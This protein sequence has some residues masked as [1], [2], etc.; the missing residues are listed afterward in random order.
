[1]KTTRLSFIEPFAAEL[2]HS[3][4]I[5]LQDKR[6]TAI[7]VF[8]LALGIGTNVGIFGLLTRFI[9]KLPVR[10]PDELVAFR[11]GSGR[12]T[13]TELNQVLTSFFVFEELRAAN[14]TLTGVF[15]FSYAAR[16]DWEMTA[17]G[18]CPGNGN[19]IVNGRGEVARFQYVSGNYFTALGISAIRGRTI[20][21]SDDNLSAAPV[22]MVSYDYWLQRFHGDP[23]VVGLPAILD[24]VPLTI[25][26]VL[27]KGLRDPLQADQRVADILLPLAV[28][29]RALEGRS[30]ADI[31]RAAFN[32]GVPATGSLSVMG[33]RKPG[34]TLAQVEANLGDVAARAARQEWETFYSSLSAKEREE[35]QTSRLKPLLTRIFPRAQVVPGSRGVLDVHPGI[36]Y[37]IAFLLT[38]SGIFLFIVCMNITNLLLARAAARQIEFGVRSALGASRGRLI[39][40]VLSESCLLASLA[41][42][43][44]LWV[45]RW[46]VLVFPMEGPDGGP[47]PLSLLPSPTDWRVLGVTLG[48]SLLVGLV[49]GVGPVWSVLR[50]NRTPALVSVVPFGGSRSLL[51]RSMLIAQVAL[52]VALLIVA[53]LFMKSVRN[54][55]DINVGFNL[56]NVAVFAIA[57]AA[58][59]YDSV[60]VQEIYEQLLNRLPGVIGVKF[61]SFSDGL[62]LAVEAIVPVS[63]PGPSDGALGTSTGRRVVH[64]DFFRTLEIPLR[65]GRTFTNRDGKSAPRVAVVSEAFVKMFFAN[66]NPI[67][68]HVRFGSDARQA[69]E[70]EIVGVVGDTKSGTN[71]EKPIVPMLYTTSLQEEVRR[72]TFEVRTAG[73][74]S[75]VLPSIREAVQAVDA[76]LPIFGLL[77]YRS[78]YEWRVIGDQIIIGQL[79]RAVG[80]L[81]LVFA[82]IGLFSLMSYTVTRRTRDIGIRMAIGA[83]RRDVLLSVL[84][85]TLS[86]A[87]TGALVG[88][89]FASALSPL[90]ESQLTG[91][92]PHDPRTIGLV[93][94]LTFVV[95]AAAGYLPAR[96]AAA[97]DPMIALRH[98]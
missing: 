81:A 96:R 14:Q 48:L 55:E 50:N 54:L 44:S 26:G 7:A 5:V 63:I 30:Q 17:R 10:N 39:R 22:A 68:R 46:P 94:A 97:V 82:M 95:S 43:V 77:T 2:R 74:P 47:S 76:S 83:Q 35:V 61:A 58:K 1:M 78:V 32:D 60:R 25:V 93:I 64:P 71:I 42:A 6:W 28:P 92:T 72:A 51:T 67:G 38:I 62:P 79:T 31:I 75:D 12:T 70:V 9:E 69:Q 41:G 29:R 87:A 85:E 16:C 45:A 19:F 49:S 57:P 40:Q 3:W 18:E 73:N 53:G 98:E 37:N 24:K 91:L 27:P 88:V 13:I 52:S 86:L 20:G 65:L 11:F 8:S 66:T 23:A 84:R 90:L 4:R 33:R 80:G 59:G 34:I 21:P 15:A 56:N 89:A 36:I